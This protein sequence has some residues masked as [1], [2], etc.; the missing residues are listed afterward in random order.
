MDTLASLEIQL[1]DFSPQ[2]RYEALQELL[3]LAREGGVEI[4]MEHEEFNLHCHTFFSFNAFG[5]SPTA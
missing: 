2:V 1:N 4:P 5:Y 3:T